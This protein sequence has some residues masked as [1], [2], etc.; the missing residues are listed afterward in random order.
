[1]K[2]EL[3]DKVLD[4][5]H[6]NNTSYVEYTKIYYRPTKVKSIVGFVISLLFFL[7]LLSGAVYSSPLFWGVIIIDFIILLYYGI[8]LFT[9]DGFLIPKYVILPKEENEEINEEIINEDNLQESDEFTIDESE[10]E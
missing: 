3:L 10:E 4:K 1:M 6:D 2:N 9:K 5:L 7:I 8:N